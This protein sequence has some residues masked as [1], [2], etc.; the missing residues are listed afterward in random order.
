MFSPSVRRVA[1]VL[2]GP[3]LALG[4]LVD[5]DAP[6]QGPQPAKRSAEFGVVV[7]K[8]VMIPMR[9]GVRLAADIY[10]PARDG[11]PAAGRF[12]TLLTRTPYNKRRRER[13]GPLLRRAGLRRGRQRRP[14]PLRQRGDLAADRRRSPGRL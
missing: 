9:D 11:K 13:R 5:R 8:N 3:V 4:W 2:V 6:R 14:G 7:E 1:I 10:R 12:P